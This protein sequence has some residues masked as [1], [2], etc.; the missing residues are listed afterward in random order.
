MFL[1]FNSVAKITV[2]FYRK[3]TVKIDIPMSYTIHN[4]II[5]IIK[6]WYLKNLYF[7]NSVTR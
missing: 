3:K 7:E 4:V 5:V 2:K 6:C 1:N